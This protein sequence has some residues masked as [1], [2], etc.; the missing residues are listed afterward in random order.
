MPRTT[1]TRWFGHAVP[2]RI[3]T[4]SLSALL[5]ACA[6]WEDLEAS[7]AVAWLLRSS[8]AAETLTEELL[9]HH[10]RARTLARNGTARAPSGSVALTYLDVAIGLADNP[11]VDI[12]DRFHESR[13]IYLAC[14]FL[15]VSPSV[16][17]PT[18][19]CLAVAL[20]RASAMGTLKGL[21]W[22]AYQAPDVARR[23]DAL[24]AKLCRAGL[25]SEVTLYWRVT[26]A[27]DLDEAV[28]SVLE[29]EDYGPLYT[30]SLESGAV[31][32]DASADANLRQLCTVRERYRLALRL[33]RQH[34]D[35]DPTARTAAVLGSLEHQERQI[36]QSLEPVRKAR[37]R[38]RR[39]A[40]LVE[41]LREHLDDSQVDVDHPDLLERL[42]RA[43]KSP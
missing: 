43:A 42:L 8:K 36:H 22:L 26:L 31:P 6:T 20:D 40:G 3:D 5:W 28:A 2:E 37:E 17:T 32:T 34:H 13:D 16:R 29:D 25:D 10:F 7:A 33:V 9:S 27:Y 21:L 12:S 18:D 1:T 15:L 39:L 23:M 35:A 38:T 41:D 4:E 11:D 24:N 14:V 30:L 19:R